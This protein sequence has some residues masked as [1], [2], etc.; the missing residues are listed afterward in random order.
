M[1]VQDPSAPLSPLEVVDALGRLLRTGALVK[2]LSV[3]SCAHNLPAEDQARIRRCVGKL[4]EVSEIDKFGFVWPSVDGQP[5]Y[6]CLMPKE[7][8]LVA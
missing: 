4:C 8:E 2:V 7:V 3:E 6:F 1:A 5:A